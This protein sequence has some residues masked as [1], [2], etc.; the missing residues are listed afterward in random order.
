[1]VPMLL[2]SAVYSEDAYQGLPGLDN[3]AFNESG[4]VTTI[5]ATTVGAPFYFNDGTNY[6][7][8]TTNDDGDYVLIDEDPITSNT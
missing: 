8:V 1:M 5:T 6:L 7:S 2:N 3:V 4:A